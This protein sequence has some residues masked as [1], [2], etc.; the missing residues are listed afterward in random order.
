VG[1]RRR[2][3]GRRVFREGCG[4]SA[5]RRR[6]RDMNLLSADSPAVTAGVGLFETMLVAGGRIVQLEE[7]LERMA[8]SCRQLDWGSLDEN[9]SAT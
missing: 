1:F 4:V 7:H 9:G 8:R 6:G 2:R 5:I 3:G